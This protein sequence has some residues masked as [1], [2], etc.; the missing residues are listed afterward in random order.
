[1]DPICIYICMHVAICLL[2]ATR[3]TV[4]GLRKKLVAVSHH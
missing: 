2:F 3:D 1:M 4:C